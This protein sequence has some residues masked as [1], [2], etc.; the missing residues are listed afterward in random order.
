MSYQARWCYGAPALARLASLPYI[1][2]AEIREEIAIALK[3]TVTSF[4]QNHCT[5]SG[6]NSILGQSRWTLHT[7]NYALQLS[8]AQGRFGCSRS[9]S[10][11]SGW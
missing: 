11:R 9:W 10:S 7:I 1:D 6:D 5:L 3:A 2:D 4:G 8:L